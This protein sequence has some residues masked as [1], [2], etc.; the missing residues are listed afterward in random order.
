MPAYSWFKALLA[1]SIS[2]P[3]M[4]F[5]LWFAQEFAKETPTFG[6]E[7]PGFITPPAPINAIVAFGVLLLVTSV[8]AAVKNALGIL[9]PSGVAGAAQKPSDLMK[10]A[11]MVSP[12]KIP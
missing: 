12:V 11:G 9:P 1:S 2:I 8:P 4:G 5:L 7:G 10:T 3:I 6:V